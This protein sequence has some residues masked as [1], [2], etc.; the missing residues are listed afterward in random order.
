[1]TG[2]K[3]SSFIRKKSSGCFLQPVIYQQKCLYKNFITGRTFIALEN[4]SM[5]S[6][7]AVSKGQ[8]NKHLT[9]IIPAIYVTSWSTRKFAMGSKV[10]AL[11]REASNPIQ[12]WQ[13]DGWWTNTSVSHCKLRRYWLWNRRFVL[14]F[15]GYQMNLTD[16]YFI[17]PVI[18]C[19]WV[20]RLSL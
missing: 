11:H 20:S 4:L 6:N 13:Q 14:C 17:C 1:M 10:I 2:S 8:R 18:T 12:Q 5:F 16:V 19:I 7:P 9:W 3:K 15:W